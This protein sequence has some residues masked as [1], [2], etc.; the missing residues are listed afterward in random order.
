MDK[1]TIPDHAK[2][3]VANLRRSQPNLANYDDWQIDFAHREWSISGDFPDETL[4]AAWIE[5]DT[6]KARADYLRLTQGE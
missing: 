4:V 5:R 2:S 1:P 3:V 6:P